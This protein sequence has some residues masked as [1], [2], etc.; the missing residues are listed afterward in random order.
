VAAVAVIVLGLTRPTAWLQASFFIVVFGPFMSR[1]WLPLS[2]ADEFAIA[3]TIV[4]ALLRFTISDGK[5]RVR[6]FPGGAWFFLFGVAGVL[7]GVLQNAP[8][9]IVGAGALLAL[10]SVAYGWAAA[11]YDLDRSVIARLGKSTW[12]V[13]A[14]VVLASVA[15]NLAI[16]AMWFERFSVG[17]GSER[18]GVA[19][20]VGALVH[21]G[22]LAQGCALLLLCLIAGWLLSIR[23]PGPRVI[24]AALLLAALILTLRRKAIVGMAV[25]TAVSILVAQRRRS[26]TFLVLVGGLIVVGAVAGPQLVEAYQATTRAYVVNSGTSPRVL[27]YQGAFELASLHFPLGSGFG[28]YGSAVAIENYSPVYYQLGFAH[29]YGLAK[30]DEYGQDAFWPAVVGEAGWLGLV[31]YSLGLLSVLAYFYRLARSSQ[32]DRV[33]GYIGLLGVL[34]WF[35]Y[36]VESA[37]SPVYLAAPLGPLLFLLCGV[38]VA[39]SSA[40][41]DSGSARPRAPSAARARSESPHKSNGPSV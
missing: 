25:A 22:Y 11:Q 2:L 4:V 28:R 15:L 40:K 37:A 7:G 19:S 31:S 20:P 26:T 36:L 34:W 35:E 5:F 18:G 14:V 9:G 24:F 23:L 13:A 16:P 39:V 8:A 10:K 21:P 27:L 17:G 1:V 41:S 3:L 33:R 30:G 29:V 12:L 32:T 38:G 6:S